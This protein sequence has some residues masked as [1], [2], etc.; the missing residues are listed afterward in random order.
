M[1]GKQKRNEGEMK[2][3]FKEKYSRNDRQNE[4]ELKE[5]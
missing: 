2:E 3:R 5:K 4:K 1:K